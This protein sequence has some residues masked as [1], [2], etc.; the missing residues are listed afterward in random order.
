VLSIG[1]II[2]FVS[3][4]AAQ[5]V[6]TSVGSAGTVDEADL[7]LFATSGAQISVANT[8]ALP[9]TVVVRHNIVAVE[10]VGGAPNMTVRFR[11]NGSGGRVVAVLKSVSFVNGVITPLLTFD[12][13]TVTPSANF[14]T[15]G[16]FN[17][18]ENFE[19]F[20]VSAYF[21][22][23]TITKSLDTATPAL[24]LLKVGS[25]LLC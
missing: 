12:S 14:Q 21:I 24:Q 9:A 13:N 3:V 1:I 10:G 19:S 16:V 7:A 5:R 20:D 18:D 8:A 25:R 4:A 15:V 23:T 11:D 22:E 17:C 6:W 2:G